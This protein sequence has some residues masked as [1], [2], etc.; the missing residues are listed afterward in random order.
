MFSQVL[1]I[2]LY[3]H[4]SA[5]CA[6][7]ID[8]NNAEGCHFRFS[9]LLKSLDQAREAAAAMGRPSWVIA[10]WRTDACGYIELIEAN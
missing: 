10:R 5:L 3:G 7:G 6:V 2:H 1:H 8:Y 9:R 4:H